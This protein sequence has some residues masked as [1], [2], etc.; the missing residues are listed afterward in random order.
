M[1]SFLVQV[2][3][4]YFYDI[5]EYE[6]IYNSIICTMYMM[7]NIYKHVLQEK[8]NVRVVSKNKKCFSS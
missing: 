5:K 3:I 2:L 8:I 1:I 6:K 7:K 4:V